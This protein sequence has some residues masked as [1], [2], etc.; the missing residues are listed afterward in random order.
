MASTND[1][2]VKAELVNDRWW[3]STVRLTTNHQWGD[4]P[5]LWYETMVFASD[6]SGEV[7]SWADLDMDRY[8]TREEAEAGHAR[9]VAKWSTRV[10]AEDAD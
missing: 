10:T 3:V 2:T 7:S 9:M 8:T 1:R 4:G 6:A 5:P